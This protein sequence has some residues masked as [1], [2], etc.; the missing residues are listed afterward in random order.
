MRVNNNEHDH[1]QQT[2]DVKRPSQR[3]PVEDSTEA[4]WS[5]RLTVVIG[6]CLMAG[7]FVLAYRHVVQALANDLIF[8]AALV[9][10]GV[11]AL[12][13][14]GRLPTAGMQ[15]ALGVGLLLAPQLLFYG[16]YA[17]LQ[18]AAP[19]RAKW[20]DIWVGG[21]ALVLAAWRRWPVGNPWR[22]AS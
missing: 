6:L 21:A 11:T 5:A 2:T 12:R 8:G 4:R 18:I 16:G 3:A 20:T 13:R 19:A 7:P 17:F 10:L 9:A 22:R 15:A 1:R 14:G